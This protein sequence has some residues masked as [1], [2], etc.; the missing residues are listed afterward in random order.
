MIQPPSAG[1]A[2]GPTVAVIAHS[3]SAVDDFSFGY[4]PSRIACDNGISGPATA[5]WNTRASSRIGSV[6]ATPH[7]QDASVNDRIAPTN[8]FTWPMRCVSHPVSGIATALEAA[9]T[10]I[11][12]VPSS[13]ETPRLPE[14]VGIA[15]FAIDVSSTFMKVASATAIVARTSRPPSRG[16]GGGGGAGG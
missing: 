12:H 13:T 8:S 7:S 11:T 6:G 9:N 1:P 5:P 4:E 15:T 3:A 16:A 10:V 2:I 14:M